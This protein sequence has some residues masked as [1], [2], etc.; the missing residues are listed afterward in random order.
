MISHFFETYK[1]LEGKATAT[2]GWRDGSAARRSIVES[3]E[4]YRAT[5]SA[6]EEK[7]AP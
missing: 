2:D 3:I 5:L 6:E 1:L 4:R 7:T